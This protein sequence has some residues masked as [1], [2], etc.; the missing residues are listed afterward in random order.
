MFNSALISIVH[1]IPISP[2]TYS[3]PVE[4]SLG[5][6]ALGFKTSLFWQR[7]SFQLRFMAIILAGPRGSRD[8]ELS[9][10]LRVLGYF[11]TCPHKQTWTVY[12]SLTSGL[13]VPA[14]EVVGDL[15]VC[16]KVT[17][18]QLSHV[19]GV[20]FPSPSYPDTHHRRNN[21]LSQDVESH[22]NENYS[23]ELSV[24]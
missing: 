18:I 22:K 19:L 20:H 10:G 24:F 17:D 23:G 15:L 13:K 21:A 1:V 6:I 11:C 4:F 2:H 7:E 14:M 16:T 5:N 12:V 8:A 3:Y 9:L